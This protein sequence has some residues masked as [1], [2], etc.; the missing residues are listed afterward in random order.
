[1][2]ELTAT[3]HSEV[4]RPIVTLVIPGFFGCSTI[5]IC[6]L[7][8]YKNLQWLID[9]YPGAATIIFL[10]IVLTVGL[11]LEE[12]GARLELHFD[13]QLSKCAEFENHFEEWFDY[14][15]LAFEREPVGHRYLRTL[16]LRL[17][18]ELGMTIATI[19]FAIG[20]LFLPASI[21]WRLCLIAGSAL[22]G[23]Y[24]FFEAKRGDKVLSELRRELLKR[25]WNPTPPVRESMER[26]A[27][28]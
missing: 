1:V 15:R 10:L 8:R 9:R 18:F 13:K 23:R 11:V 16:V 27:L 26:E 6:L 17:K 7:E 20:A 25:D 21:L 5:S 14:L 2:K 3:F 12:F 28:S 4:F 24:L 19:P 22:L